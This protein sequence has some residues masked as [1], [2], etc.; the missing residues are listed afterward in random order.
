MLCLTTGV[1]S[2][3]FWS[4]YFETKKLEDLFWVGV[5]AGLTLV[6]KQNFG[7]AIILSN[8]IFLLLLQQPN[9]L[10]LFGKMFLGLLAVGCIQASYF[11]VTGSFTAY[12]NDMR[13]LLFERILLGGAFRS[14]LPWQYPAPVLHQFLKIFLY[15]LPFFISVLAGVVAWYK[16]NKTLLYY[17]ILSVSYYGLSIRPTTDYVHLTPLLAFASFP[18]IYFCSQ[19]KK[20]LQKISNFFLLTLFIFGIYSSLFQNYYRWDPP[21]ITQNYFNSNPQILISSDTSTT[22]E[23]QEILQ[24][25]T[26]NAPHEKYLFT[27]SFASTFNVLTLKN[28]PTRFDY[29]HTGVLSSATEAEVTADLQNKNVQY[30]LT[31]VDVTLEKD[32]IA[33]FIIKNYLP[34]KRSGNYTIWKKI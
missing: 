30:I 11:F 8:C 4:N 2:V 33:Q 15:T 9:K 19:L 14:I 20:Q 27:Y 7:V 34:V 28:N 24:F 29:L 12:Y 23:V 21:L 22:L 1:I 17:S 6:F 10:Q 5:F 16:N 18:L 26:K 31:D 32:L 13:F 3:Y 25:F